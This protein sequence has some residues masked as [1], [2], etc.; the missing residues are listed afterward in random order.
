MINIDNLVALGGNVKIEV[1]PDDLKMFAE[2]IVER[3]IL[4]HERIAQQYPS[5]TEETFIGTKEVMAMLGVCEGTLIAWA[6]RAYLVPT[7]VGNRN[8]YAVSEVKRLQSGRRSE[9]VAG[10]CRRNRQQAV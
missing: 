4:A 8:Y 6:K 9:T 3:T 5:E 10:Y 7:K 2:S 1:S